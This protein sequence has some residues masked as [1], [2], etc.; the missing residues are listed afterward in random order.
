MGV[1]KFHDWR[2]GGFGRLGMHA[3]SNKKQAQRENEG[4]PTC[5]PEFHRESFSLPTEFLE[6]TGIEL[7]GT[8]LLD[9]E[10]HKTSLGVLYRRPWQD[11][12]SPGRKHRLPVTPVFETL[13]ANFSIRRR[14]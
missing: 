12:K 13:T 9:A 3:R 11:W 8:Q 1:S 4:R 7:R 2:L 6:D 14:D 5:A 10:F